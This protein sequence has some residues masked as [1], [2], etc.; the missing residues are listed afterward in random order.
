DDLAL[1]VV[2]TIAAALSL[3]LLTVQ[4][5]LF[6][7]AITT[8]VVLMADTLGEDALTAAGQRAYATALGIGIAFLAFVVWPN[9]GEGRG[10]GRPP[11]PAPL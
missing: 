1:A 11:A 2:L 9:P 5:A 8:Y 4:Y 7:A 3:G 6:T 10:F